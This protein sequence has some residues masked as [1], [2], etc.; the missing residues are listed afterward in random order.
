LIR[1]EGERRLILDL[2]V[3][4]N[5]LEGSIGEWRGAKMHLEEIW[6]LSKNGG[7]RRG[8]SI[9]L[10][11]ELKYHLFNVTSNVTCISAFLISSKNYNCVFLE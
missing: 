6:L 9:C 11:L 1:G 5:L 4:F 2:V 7:I 8:D 3:W 10:K